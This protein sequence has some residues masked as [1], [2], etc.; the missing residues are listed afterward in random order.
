MASIQKH[1]NVW[2]VHWDENG[3]RKGKSLKTGD[4][5]EAL[6][7]LKLHDDQEAAKRHAKTKPV[8]YLH[9]PGADPVQLKS[10]L[11]QLSLSDLWYKWKEWAEDGN[12]SRNTVVSYTTAWKKFKRLHVTYVRDVNA[13]TVK[14]F[15]DLCKRDGL[16]KAGIMQYMISL[17]GIW[18]TS[19]EQKW[20][21]GSNPFRI[22]W[23]HKRG[24]EEEPWLDEKRLDAVVTKAVELGDANTILH[25]A[26]MAYAGLRKDEGANLLSTAAKKCSRWRLRNAAPVGIIV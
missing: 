20:I 14:N 18:S 8:V 23:Q 10:E 6:R 25:V 26:L 22:P 21:T 17:Q 9:Q 13:E 15:M 24:D 7:L 1:G 5:R 12:R 3:R 11:E 16:G 19:I 2:Y 4:K